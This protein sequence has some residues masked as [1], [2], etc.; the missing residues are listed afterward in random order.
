MKKTTWQ[1]QTAKNRFSEL[2][3]KAESGEPQLVT[4]SGKPVV[5]VI[6][7]GTFNKRISA[8]KKSK[9]EVLQARPHKEIELHVNR[10]SDYGR[11]IEI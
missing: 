6:D 4:K 5:Y 7:V 1:L 8:K 10:D 3:A 2:V 11:D 9:L